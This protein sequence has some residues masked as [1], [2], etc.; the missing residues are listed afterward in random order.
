MIKDISII[1][2]YEVYLIFVIP[3]IAISLDKEEIG[4][5]NCLF[6]IKFQH[7]MIFKIRNYFLFHNLLSF[8]KNLHF[9]GKFFSYFSSVSVLKG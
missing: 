1:L 7:K 8:L 5:K 4:N 9:K 6:L 2:F 3:F